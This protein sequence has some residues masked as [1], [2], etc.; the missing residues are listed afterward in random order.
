METTTFD[1][2]CKTTWSQSAKNTAMVFAWVVQ[3]GD[4]GTIL[5]FQL[6]KDSISSF[7][8]NDSCNYKWL[9]N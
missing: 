3:L 1:W 4:F 9:N 2:S 7:S 8:N 5:F 6:M